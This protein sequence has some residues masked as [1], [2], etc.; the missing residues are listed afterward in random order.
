MT[1]TDSSPEYLKLCA[2]RA[3]WK[4]R[5]SRAPSGRHTWADWFEKKFGESLNSF[6]ERKKKDKEN[7]QRRKD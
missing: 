7:D 2:A 1:C 6:A 3:V 4:Y 5:H